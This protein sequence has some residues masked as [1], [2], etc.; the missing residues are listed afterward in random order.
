MTEPAITARQQIYRGKVVGLEVQTLSLRDGRSVQNEVVLHRPCVAMVVVGADGRIV[1]VRQF[2]APAE[3]ELLEIPAGSID[4]GEEIEVAVQRELQEEIGARAQ[5][6]QRL[7]GFYVAPGYCSEYIHIYVCEDL[8]E[9]R[10][11]ADDDELIDVERLTL[12]EALELIASGQIQDAKSVAGLL[13]YA[14][15][16]R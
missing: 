2:R 6:I 9:S 7:G 15:T 14:R 13:L 3:A 5:R 8:T 1:L 11:P 4:E 16:A 10:L 12:A